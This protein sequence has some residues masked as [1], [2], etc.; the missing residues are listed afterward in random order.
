VARH[1]SSAVPLAWLYVGLIVYASLYP[2][3]E[4]RVPGAAP[5]H[6]LVMPWSRYW[7][8]FDL[9][10]NLLGYLPLGLLVFG[11]RVRAGHPP[12]RSVLV[13][14]VM[15]AGLSFAMEFAQNYLPQRVASNVDLVL[16]LA[17]TATGA[18]L[19]LVVRLLGGVERW[20]AVR[21]RWFSGG[22]AGGLALLL[23]WPLGLLFPAP[24]PLGLGQVWGRLQEALHG[25]LDGSPVLDWLAPWLVA[26]SHLE[27]LSAGQ[28][29]ATVALG[30][31]APC[32]IALTI[33]RPGWR[34]LALVLGAA[35]LGAGATTLSTAMNFGPEHAL[36]WRTP[37]AVGGFVT[38]A[39]LAALLVWLPQR[40]AA[41]LG[42]VALSGLVALVAHAQTDPY[43]AHSLQAWEQGRFIRFHGAA[44]WVGWLWPYAALLYL[45]VRVG[46]RAED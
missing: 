41:G 35:L 23:L 34:R 42:L 8:G 18:G 37:N 22:S 5:L 39:M 40:A 4:W 27:H 44:Q 36:A 6:F 9:V 3:G 29:L 16:N 43:F 20:Q 46:A 21:E 31:L 14:T 15:G 30:L 19:G 7:T 17:G 38:G 32:M 13:A 33:A 11:A 10:S 25:A 1:R 2:F 26:E 28:E 12:G 24:V 45:L